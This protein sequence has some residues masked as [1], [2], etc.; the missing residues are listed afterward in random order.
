MGAIVLGGQSEYSI[1]FHIHD[2]NCVNNY[3]PKWL[4][5]FEHVIIQLMTTLLFSFQCL[6]P[7]LSLCIRPPKY[8]IYVQIPHDGQ[9]LHP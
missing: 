3:K 6:V 4:V 7:T 1:S 5:N 8:C 2:P 9:N